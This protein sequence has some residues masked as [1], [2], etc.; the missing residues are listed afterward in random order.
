MAKQTI[1]KQDRQGKRIMKVL[2]AIFSVYTALCLALLI[3][4]SKLPDTSPILESIAT[5]IMIMWFGIPLFWI[6]YGIYQIATT[7]PVVPKVKERMPWDKGSPIAVDD[8]WRTAQK[9]NKDDAK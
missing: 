2:G 8:E 7:K 1:E 9:E 6:I 3:F 5:V 4:S